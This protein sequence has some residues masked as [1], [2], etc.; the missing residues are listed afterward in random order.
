VYYMYGANYEKAKK[1]FEATKKNERLRQLLDDVTPAIK[2]VKKLDLFGFL[3]LPIQRVPRYSLLLSDLLK[4]TWKAHPDYHML[5]EA[6]LAMQKAG[7]VLNESRKGL[8]EKNK[9]ISQRGKQ[10]S[11]SDIQGLLERSSSSACINEGPVI[12]NHTTATEDD[13]RKYIKS[14]LFL[15]SDQLIIAKKVVNKRM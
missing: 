3:I 5:A 13:P 14:E 11:S 7:A 1:N 8:D 9:L 12:S 4:R 2:A 6:V 15:F 10:A